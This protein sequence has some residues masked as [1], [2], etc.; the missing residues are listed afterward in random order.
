M[1][2][3]SGNYWTKFLQGKPV[4][5]QK[6]SDNTG[7]MCGESGG[8]VRSQEWQ[9]LADRVENPFLLVQFILSF[10][11]FFPLTEGDTHRLS[12][13]WWETRILSVYR[14]GS[15]FNPVFYRSYNIICI[16]QYL[17]IIET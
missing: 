6:R 13:R 3:A 14:I 16:V 10:Y 1:G 11:I 4:N 7:L 12:H 9:P 15:F 8:E 2:G 17:G 5:W